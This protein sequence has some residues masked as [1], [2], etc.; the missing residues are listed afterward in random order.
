[1]VDIMRALGALLVLSLALPAWSQNRGAEFTQR[2]IVARKQVALVIGNSAYGNSP[3][4]NPANDAR[5]LTARLQ[6]LNYDVV[7]VF[8]AN[9][10]AMG[11]AIEQFVGKLGTGDVALFF[12]AGHG[13]QVDGENYLLPV[14]FDGQDEIDVR[15]D[16][17]AAGKIQDRM[18][19]SGAQLNIL[20][21]DACRN[22]PYRGANRAGT[23][24]LAAMSAGRG[25]LIAFATAPGRTASD[26]GGDNGLFTEHLLGALSTPGLMLGELFDVVREQVDTASNGAQIPW[27]LSSVVGRY[28]FVNRAPEPPPT[29]P[30]S[31]RAGNSGD[32]PSSRAVV[33]PPRRKSAAATKR[34]EIPAGDVAFWI[35]PN[36]WKEKSR[37]DSRIIFLHNNAKFFGLVV[38]EAAGGIPTSAMRNVALIN[39]RNADPNVRAVKE[40]RRMVNGREVMY[41]EM[42]VTTQGIPFRF[43]GYYHGGTKSNLQVVGYTVR[44]EFDASKKELEEFI[45]SIEIR[46]PSVPDD[47]PASSIDPPPSRE[48]SGGSV[49]HGAITLNF[50]PAKWKANATDEAG[51][52]ELSYKPGDAY[53]KLIVENLELPIDALIDI[54]LRN[55]KEQDPQ[56]KVI[57]R[58]DRKVS[59][60]PVKMVRVDVAPQGIP[61]TFLIYY[62]GGK[63]GSVQML[64]WC[65]RQ[66]FAAKRPILQSLLDGLVIKEP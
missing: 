1:M 16:A 52:F 56:Y 35:D 37:E 53:G 48:I 25:T 39:A 33:G 62:Y 45:N 38:A 24:G 29:Q 4:K 63:A 50:D 18:E 14:D 11:R 31:F 55:M 12:F 27:T 10:R 36:K 54:A 44:S 22:N 9:R 21:L 57:S 64:A 66:Q 13:V 2:E 40:E 46:E 51:S 34:V 65:A 15:N 61:V 26:G 28:A 23:R 32:A 49:K 7:S 59:G 6:A 41:L 20:I 60:V 19:K 30:N 42:D 5:A 8:D 17:V 58:E 43:A 3:L 47:A